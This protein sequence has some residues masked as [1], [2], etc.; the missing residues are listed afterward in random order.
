MIFFGKN[1]KKDKSVENTTTVQD[2]KLSSDIIE[3]IENNNIE[4]EAV[5]VNPEIEEIL[6][7]SFELNSLNSSAENSE[8]S[9]KIVKIKKTRIKNKKIISKILIP[10][11]KLSKTAFMKDVAEIFFKIFAPTG[12]ILY[13]QGYLLGVLIIRFNEKL[14]DLTSDSIISISKAL[15]SLLK[16]I[17]IKP[18]VSIFV[19]MRKFVFEFVDPFSDVASATAIAYESIKNRKAIKSED[20]DDNKNDIRKNVKD[21]LKSYL[22]CFCNILNHIAPVAAAVVLVFIVG[23]TS[24]LTFAL[25]ISYNGENLGY[26]ENELIFEEAEK[27]VQSRVVYENIDTEQGKTKSTQKDELEQALSKTDD[28]IITDL[29]YVKNTTDVKELDSTQTE[30]KIS[31]ANAKYSLKIIEKEEVENADSLCDKLI[32]NL[33]DVIVEASGFYV[34]GVFYGATEDGNYV[35]KLLKEKIAT[36]DDGTGAVSFY[37]PVEITDGLY[38]KDVVLSDSDFDSLINSTV[39]GKKEYVI[40]AGDA[41]LS[42]AAKNNI[43][44]SDLKALN[45]NIET[46]CMPGDVVLIS[47]EEQFLQVMVTKQLTYTREIGYDS[48]EVK[49]DKQYVGYTK[50]TQEGVNGIDEIVANVSYLDG[51]EVNREVIKTTTIKE[52]VIKKVLKGTKQF[53][54]STSTG[55]SVTI[56]SNYKGGF[57]WPTIG[58][59]MTCGWLGYYRHYGVDICNSYGTPVLASAPGVVTYAGWNSW[60]Y[61]NLVKIDHGNGYVTLYAHN[62]K[63]NVSVGQKVSQGQQIAAM[64]QTGNAYGNHVHF[65]IHYN[66]R[67]INPEPFLGLR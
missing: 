63:L 15:K 26:V 61:G 29:S 3:K 14:W 20:D 57:A 27:M 35:D 8:S 13:K 33:S 45:P 6:N 1:F 19:F 62:S 51:V 50:V 16:T 42:I 64:G 32:Q 30:N 52:P 25:E 56:N 59:K 46:V 41:P 36:Y 23:R 38:P 54:V 60:G 31:K 7:S 34:D 67:A 24:K 39:A 66:G 48:E 5:S 22:K 21:C 37:K 9:V 58:G 2:S 49:T 12:K 40:Q 11:K 47:K 65:E 17:I 18:L 53:S 28:N 55:S 4:S 43:P 44:Y 10:F